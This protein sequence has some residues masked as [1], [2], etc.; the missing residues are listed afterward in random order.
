MNALAADSVTA[1]PPVVELTLAPDIKFKYSLAP[2]VVSSIAP[3]DVSDPTFKDCASLSVNAPT[4]PVAMTAPIA[5]A[6]ERLT[7]PAPLSLSEAAV[8]TPAPLSVAP[9]ATEVVAGPAPTFHEPARL[10]VPALTV[11][12]PV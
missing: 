12:A 10:R 1:V 3:L 11:V 4:V 2:L 7:V 6:P 9:L 5:L 8:I